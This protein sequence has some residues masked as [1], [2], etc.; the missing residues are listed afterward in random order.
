M[1]QAVLFDLDGTLLNTL[2]D[3]ADSMNDTLR[4]QG[5]PV[6]PVEQYKY[7]VGNGMRMLAVR[8]LPEQCRDERCV[9][10]V[11][12]LFMQRYNRHALDKTRPYDG[13]LETLTA[14]RQRQIYTAV[15]TNKA[16]AAA[17]IV[18]SRYFEHC[19]D[20]VFGQKEGIPTK[21]D[22]QSTKLVLAQLGVSPEQCLFVGDSGVDMQTAQNAGVVAVG[23]LWGFRTKQELLEN[24]AA[25]VLQRPEQLLRLIEDL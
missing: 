16:H 8:A 17:Q 3:L 18:L 14:L 5:Y 20:V 2:D 9:Q 22:P 24:G 15:I 4:R 11:L 23:A 13:V 19:F 10:Q 21:P 7:M 12:E 1:I 25:Y 6:H